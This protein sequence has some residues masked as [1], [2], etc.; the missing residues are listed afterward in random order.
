[1]PFVNETEHSF[2][3]LNGNRIYYR[4]IKSDNETVRMVISHG[5]GEHSGRY[6]NVIER[7]YPAGV[8]FWIHDHYGHGKSDGKRGH[9]DSFD[10]YIE[11]LDKMID[12]A[13]SESDVKTILLGH[14][15]GGLIA[16]NYARMRPEKLSGLVVSSPFLKPAK[17][18]PLPLEVFG[19][20]M[21]VILPGLTLS[22]GLEASAVSHDETVIKAYNN[23]D[24]V[25]DRISARWFAEISRA[26]DIT[27]ASADRITLP[28]MMQLAGD[29]HLVCAGTSQAFFKAISAQDKTLH[30]YD[31]LYH[32]IYNEIKDQREKVLDDL[33]AW[34]INHL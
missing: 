14:S 11:D 5:L 18:I 4:K 1:M 29:D 27:G 3:G 8:S 21:S 28:V 6:A 2:S 20:I 22:N 7:L 25:H 34:I 17:K 33:Q 12:I 15:M 9:I 30:V 23:S 19:K 26:M 24:L 32:E 13:S 31:G 10:Q 16:L